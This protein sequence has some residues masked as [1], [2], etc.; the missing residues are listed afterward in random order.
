MVNGKIAIIFH[1]LG[2][3]HIARIRG[4]RQKI[5]DIVVVE[6]ASHD[7]T[8]D[9]T[10]P[11]S[12]EFRCITLVEG[13]YE[14]IPASR[15]VRLVKQVLDEVR[16][17]CVVMA[18]Y[19]HPAM[20]AAA[21]WARRRDGTA[22]VFFSESQMCDGPRNPIKE[23]IKGVWIKKHFDAAFVGGSSAFSYLESLGFAGDRIWRGYNVVDNEYFATRAD[24]LRHGAELLRPQL[25][26]PGRYFLY[27]GR[28]SPEKNLLKLLHAYKRYREVSGA[29]AWGLVMVG[30]GPQEAELMA[31]AAELH[32]E[33]VCWP[34]FKQINE[35]PQYYAL[36]SAFVLPSLREPWGLVVNEAMASGLPVLVSTRCGCV[37]DLVYPGL[38]GWVVDPFSEVSM[39]GALVRLSSEATDRKTMGEVS[40]SIVAN[41]TPETW[42]AALSDC[43][44]FA[45]SEHR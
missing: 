36:A 7:G 12:V 27:V 8:R 3:Y 14:E 31:R 1:N 19:G 5:K 2:P 44:S 38:N 9:W 42:A 18:G 37:L 32:I 29:G 33:G 13:N 22:T 39:A 4:L 26:L 10:R 30:S 34:G 45:M 6:L 16:P 17:R 25:G 21:R 15:F 20:R 23:Y 24:A 40:K 35:L 43:I 11:D 28:F 41:Y